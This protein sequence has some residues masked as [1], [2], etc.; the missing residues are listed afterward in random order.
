MRAPRAHKKESAAEC[1]RAGNEAE[2]VRRVATPRSSAAR[3][4]C[5]EKRKEKICACPK[6]F[7]RLDAKR[8]K[9]TCERNKKSAPAGWMPAGAFAVCVCG[10]FVLQVG[11]R[12]VACILDF[13]QE[14][15][16][17]GGLNRIAFAEFGADI[18]DGL[19]VRVC[20]ELREVLPKINISA[21]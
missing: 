11:A 14:A 16:N 5:G 8:R 3:V 21:L 19:P 7:R 13:V 17:F 6:H 15:V 9:T 1:E 12:I 2:N 18:V 20:I 4:C 10:A